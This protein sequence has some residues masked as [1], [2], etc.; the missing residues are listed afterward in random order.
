[1]IPLLPRHLGFSQIRRTEAVFSRSSPRPKRLYIPERLVMIQSGRIYLVSGVEFAQDGVERAVIPVAQDFDPVADQERSTDS[2]P[3]LVTT[4]R[5]RTVIDH[6]GPT[7]STDVHEERQVNVVLLR[8]SQ[9]GFGNT[10]HLGGPVLP[11]IA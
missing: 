5:P 9:H 3:R 2:L 7:G 10:K 4:L 11:G 8:H 6:L 1:M